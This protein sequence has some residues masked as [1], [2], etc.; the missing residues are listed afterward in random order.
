MQ[1]QV[2]LPAFMASF[3]V[4]Q[5][6]A[7]A[8]RGMQQ[9][10]AQSTNTCTHACSA[11]LLQNMPHTRLNDNQQ[12]EKEGERVWETQEKEGRKA[13]EGRE[14]EKGIPG[15]RVGPSPKHRL[16]VRVTELKYVVL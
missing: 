9:G 13:E 11:C 10:M 16:R 1:L 3:V 7:D 4:R 8:A 5:R 2:S 6:G 12:E 15:G 14:A